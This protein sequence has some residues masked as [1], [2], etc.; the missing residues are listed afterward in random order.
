MI[1]DPQVKASAKGARS[2]RLASLQDLYPTLVKRAGLEVPSHVHG[3]DLAGTIAGETFEGEQMALQTYKEEN[4]AIRTPEYR[5]IRYEDGSEELYFWEVDPFEYVNRAGMLDAES[6]K[7]LDDMRGKMDEVLE[8][9]AG[10]Y[11]R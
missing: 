7:A 8:M 1:R 11:G 9:G 2:N 5:Y 4:H 3:Y 10:D 6:K